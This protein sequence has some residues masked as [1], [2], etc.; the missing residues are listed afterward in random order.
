VESR[1]WIDQRNDSETGLTYLHARYYDSRRG[2]FLS[3]DPIGPTGG[4]N[5]YGYSLASPTNGS[6]RSGLLMD[7]A[8]GGPM[9][10]ECGGGA[11]G[12]YFILGGGIGISSGD[13][14]LDR[15]NDFYRE[16]NAARNTSTTTITYADGST[17]T[18]T[19]NADGTVSTSNSAASRGQTVS[20]R[21][22]GCNESGGVHCSTSV[23]VDVE[24]EG[25]RTAGVFILGR[26]YVGFR[27]QTWRPFPSQIFK[28]NNQPPR[29]TPPPP[30]R[31]GPSLPPTIQEITKPGLPPPPRAPFTQR[32][33]HKLRTINRDFWDNAGDLL[34][35]MFTPP[36]V[37][38]EPDCFRP[39]ACIT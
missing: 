30:L 2:L 28:P 21:S 7:P 5:Q 37:V 1:G 23:T 32:F 12:Y 36:P 22:G 19:R 29:I 24:G 20:E 8:C 26:P 38:P 9:H 13:R 17:Q 14:F 6:D 15:V 16:M 39:E 18:I 31:P 27:P 33:M 25:R 3:P 11:D 10:S 34:D 35:E 4:L